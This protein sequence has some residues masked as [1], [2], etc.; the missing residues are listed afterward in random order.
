[1]TS[2][3]SLFSVVSVFEAWVAMQ[4]TKE[5]GE[6]PTT[7]VA[8]SRDSQGFLDQDG[9]NLDADSLDFFLEAI[10]ASELGIDS[11][12]LFD[13]V[14]CQVQFDNGAVTM[15]GDDSVALTQ[16][17]NNPAHVSQYKCDITYLYS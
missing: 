12:T 9:N 15:F 5:G 13:K 11:T 17:V 8:I 16:N 2:L 1:M 10:G 4:L 6:V 14:Q 7:I 3:R